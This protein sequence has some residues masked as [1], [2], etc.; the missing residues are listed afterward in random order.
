M[1]PTV[2]SAPSWPVPWEG[3]PWTPRR[4]QAEALPVILA[5]ARERKRGLVSAIMGSGKSVLQAEIV[6]TALPGSNG[7]AIVLSAP[8]QQLVRQLA[9]TVEER[10]GSLW[11]VGRFY[12]DE[13]DTASDVLVSC[14]AS[15][16]TLSDALGD[17]RVSLLILDEAHGSEAGRVKA[18]ALAMRPAVLVG[19]TATPF[20][21][22][23]REN[24]S[25]YDEVVYRYTMEQAIADGCLVP[26]RVV[27]W[28]GAPGVPVDL[29]CEAMIREH[30]D[31]PGIVSAPTIEDAERYAAWLSERG[32]PA[33]AI[34][35]GHSA[36]ERDDRLARLKAGGVRCLVHVALLSEGVDLPW[37]RWICLRRH[38]SARVRFIQE[39]GRVLR[40]HVG[41][42]EG[43][44]LDPHLLLGKHGLNAV[45][46]LG[47][48]LLQAAMAEER[49]PAAEA[50]ER[51]DHEVVAM[52]ALSAYLSALRDA[53]ETA[54]VCK[55]R[56]T[57]E[58]GDGWRFA[59]LSEKQAEAVRKAKSLTRHIPEPYRTPVKV[60]TTVPY[61][62]N[63]GEVSDLLDVLYQG[64]QY[65]R[66]NPPRWCREK[67]YMAQWSADLVRVPV[68]C[69][70][71]VA[72]ARKM[73]P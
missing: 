73:K 16:Q 50:R 68:P 62:L 41:K 67:P 61:A 38:V 56:W 20:R 53:L 2:T 30:T 13:K 48:L 27:R 3:A 1:V 5:A 19:F 37:L 32:T 58:D 40:A 14:N 66:A 22:I 12:A 25:L 15:L 23:P 44:I 9:A 60:L 4:W 17:R 10:L 31:G 51:H 34:H 63:R 69:D 72:V 6:E 59:E 29:A 24:L 7:R 54:G 70:E 36:T 52:E 71:D 42:T 11:S 21:S 33:L 45:E 26:P 18:A 28:G 65:A 43:V 8:R 46:R 49:D 35:S 64:A 39:L 47:E 57:S 55:A